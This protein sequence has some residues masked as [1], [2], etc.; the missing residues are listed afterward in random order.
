MGQ[1]ITVPKDAL[2]ELLRSSG[3]T[4]TPE[5]FVA[6]LPGSGEYRKYPGRARV[7]AGSRNVLL[8]VAILAA[9]CLPFNLDSFSAIVENVIVVAGLSVVTYFE[10]R[11][12]LYFLEGNPA[13]PDLGFR[14]EACFAAG[15]LVYGLYHAVFPAQL[16]SVGDVRDLVD[17]AL[18][19]SVQ[20]G[21]SVIYVIVGIVG[22]ASQFGLA[23][24]YRCAR[25]SSP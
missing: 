7:A 18:L 23:W 13:A 8:V 3:S 22:G 10:N 9:L 17:P 5:Q 20:S 21:V 19:S 15:L 4:L 24:Y 12:R 2:A 25:I 6:S 14:N 1:L 11:T 16:S